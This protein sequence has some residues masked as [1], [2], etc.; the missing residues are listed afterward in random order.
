MP[1]HGVQPLPAQ[2]TAAVQRQLLR[3]QAADGG[4]SEGQVRRQRPCGRGRPRHRHACAASAR[5]RPAARGAHFRPLSDS[6]RLPG[7]PAQ[8][9]CMPKCRQELVNTLDLR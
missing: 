7:A 8:A 3:A 4:P 2:P 1:G 9:T 5:R 6:K